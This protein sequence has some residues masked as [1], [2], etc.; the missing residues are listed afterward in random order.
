MEM[1]G[2][3]QSSQKINE[4]IHIYKCNYCEN[5]FENPR[6]IEERHGLDTPPYE[7]IAVCPYCLETGFEEYNEEKEECGE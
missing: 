3:F 4:V 5:K 6:I 7:Y 2:L 1:D